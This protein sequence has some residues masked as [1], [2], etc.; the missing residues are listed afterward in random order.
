MREWKFTC[1]KD[2][3]SVLWLVLFCVLLQSFGLCCSLN[4]EGK[5]F[6]CLWC[7]V[8]GWKYKGERKLIFFLLFVG[9]A[10]LKFKQGIVSDPFD[11]LSNWVDDGVWVDPCNWF[12]VECSD[13]RV[14]VL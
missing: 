5:G 2:L 1:F 14:V 12:G 13:G 7:F 11:A 10:L 6:C 3:R 4:D 9:K 8:C